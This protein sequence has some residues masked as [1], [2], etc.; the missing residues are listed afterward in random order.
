M[1]VVGEVIQ[2]WM[3]RCVVPTLSQLL[4]GAIHPLI[5]ILQDMNLVILG[6]KKFGNLQEVTVSQFQPRAK[7][8]MSLPTI[9]P[10]DLNS[11]HYV[12]QS[13]RKFD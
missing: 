11:L 3:M 1:D 9:F 6:N 8:A 12:T 7:K 5:T 10:N 2:F 4:P 13:Q